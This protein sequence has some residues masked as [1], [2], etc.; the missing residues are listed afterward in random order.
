MRAIIYPKLE[1]SNIALPWLS[2]L[3]KNSTLPA[4]YLKILLR[5]VHKKIKKYLLKD[6]TVL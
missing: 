6:G 1:Y 2:H 5:L 3:E 4:L